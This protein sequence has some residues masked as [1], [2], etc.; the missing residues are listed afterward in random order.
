MGGVMV[1][2]MHDDTIESQSLRLLYSCLQLQMF[3]DIIIIIIII[4]AVVVVVVVVVFVTVVIIII[5]TIHL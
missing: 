2:Y 3:Q 4:S 1:S 5:I